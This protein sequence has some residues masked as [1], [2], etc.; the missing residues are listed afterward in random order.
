MKE[1][2]LLIRHY[3]RVPLELPLIVRY[4]NIRP[5]NYIDAEACVYDLAEGRFP[6]SV[7]LAITYGKYLFIKICL[8][9]LEFT[10]GTN[11]FSN[12]QNTRAHQQRLRLRLSCSFL[13]SYVCTLN[14]W[15]ERGFMYN[16]HR[17]QHLRAGRLVV[18][19]YVVDI[20]CFSYTTKWSWLKCTA[21]YYTS[22]LAKL[23]KHI[24]KKRP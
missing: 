20:I 7:R 17:L 1:S 24:A 14:I 18:L 15:K 16:I 9:V 12:K 10:L 3:L 8:S 19:L 4:Q 2:D 13:D 6:N 23:R 21:V 11:I 5:L 22:V